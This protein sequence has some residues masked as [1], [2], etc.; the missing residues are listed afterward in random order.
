MQCDGGERAAGCS[1]YHLRARMLAAPPRCVAGS[2][3]TRNRS[4]ATLVDLDPPLIG[5]GATEPLWQGRV[6]THG[7]M[8]EED[9]ARQGAAVLEDDAFE[10]ATHALETRNE[11]LIQRD[12]LTREGRT[13]FTCELAWTIRAEHH[14]SSPTEK[15]QRRAV[16]ARSLAEHGHGL[17]PHLPAIAVEAVVGTVAVQGLEAGDGG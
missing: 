6:Q 9:L 12:G 15:H 8:K 16:A 17:I 1:E 3:H 4:A 5:E 10:L 2:K 11:L 13:L 14:V 7:A